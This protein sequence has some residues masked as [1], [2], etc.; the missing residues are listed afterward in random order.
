MAAHVA[1]APARTDAV[2]RTGRVV[3][4]RRWQ[5]SRRRGVKVGESV[6]RRT[7]RIAAC[8]KAVALSAQFE[9]VGAL[10]GEGDGTR[11]AVAALPDRLPLVLR[12]CT[13]LDV[14]R[15]CQ[16]ERW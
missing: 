11:A 16:G 6:A 2:K 13:Q 12:V 5:S 7:K 15:R 9:R 8:A 10:P 14:S 1:A 3:R 4:L